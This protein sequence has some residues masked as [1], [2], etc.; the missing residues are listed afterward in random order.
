MTSHTA[1]ALRQALDRCG[2]NKTRAAQLLGMTARQ[3]HYRWQKL[4]A[5]R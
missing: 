1:D 3:F 4:V 5:I 2:G